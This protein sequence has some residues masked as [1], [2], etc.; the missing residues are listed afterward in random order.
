MTVKSNWLQELPESRI[1]IVGLGL[2]G[3]SLAMAVRD[4]VVSITAVDKDPEVLE[5]A[6]NWGL[7][8]QVSVELESTLAITD[9]LILATP[10]SNIVTTL[11]WL[12]TRDYG[13]LAILDL[14]S[15][16]VQIC[17]LMSRLPDDI[18]AIGGHPLCGREVSGLES[19]QSTLYQDQAFV[20]CRTS[21]TNQELER[22]ILQL[23]YTLG[24]QPVFMSPAS[25]D[26]IVA[27]TSHLP[28]IM[29]AA[30]IDVVDEI[31]HHHRQTWNISAS[32]LRDTSRLAGSNPQ[33][34]LDILLSNK[35][36][37]VNQ[38]ETFGTT[39]RKFAA[40]LEQEDD[41]AL[42]EWLTAI[43]QQYWTYRK[44]KY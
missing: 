16:K 42:L 4:Q 1:T 22:L 25:H 31:A 43:Q 29:S 28:F 44:I 8:D 10:V 7:V 35:K 11:A 15:T 40:L 32:G 37:V 33:V 19:A 5:K 18:M 23:V 13:P 14:G 27:A 21:R 30:L 39:I 3:G 6:L 38:L 2:M 34:M 36:Y 9:L 41:A 17:E 12:A 20:L 26:E 24:S